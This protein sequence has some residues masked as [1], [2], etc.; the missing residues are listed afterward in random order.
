MKKLAII[1]RSCDYESAM[2]AFMLAN[3]SKIRGSDV[4]IYMIFRG[5]R[6]AKKGFKPRYKG[7]LAPLTG[8]FENRIKKQGF[9]NF[10]DQLSVA[11]ELGVNLYVCDLCVRIGLLKR[12]QLIEGVEVIGMPRFAEIAE[13]SDQ[14][15]SF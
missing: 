10:A 4:H 3:A 12:E 6:I 7:L 8:A 15:F 13:S 5:V 14:R 1:L 9:D 2:A 11:Q